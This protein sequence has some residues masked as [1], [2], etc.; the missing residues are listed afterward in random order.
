MSP[1]LCN[2]ELTA[3]ATSAQVFKLGSDA[4][5]LRSSCLSTSFPQTIFPAQ[6]VVSAN[7]RFPLAELGIDSKTSCMQGKPS[8][9]ELPPQTQ[10][11]ALKRALHCKV[12]S[13]KSLVQLLTEFFTLKLVFQTLVPAWDHQPAPDPLLNI[14]MSLW[15]LACLLAVLCSGAAIA[16]QGT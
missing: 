8:I 12:F 3:A 10:S 7:T 5:K 11:A 1:T 14:E 6:S 13:S 9:T 15:L 2:C 16:T 4:P